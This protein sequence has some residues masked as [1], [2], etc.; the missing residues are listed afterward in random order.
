MKR[1]S[2]KKAFEPLDIRFETQAEVDLFISLIGAVP[3]TVAKEFG[4]EMETILDTWE[5]VRWLSSETRPKV[6][7][8]SVSDD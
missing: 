8:V 6:A 4:V 7:T 1:V 5:S 2:L 3:V